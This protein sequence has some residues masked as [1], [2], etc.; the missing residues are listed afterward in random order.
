VSDAEVQEL[1]SQ[2]S[3][4]RGDVYGQLERQAQALEDLSGLFAELNR[5]TRSL[6]CAAHQ[7]R[8][9]RL[10]ARLE[11]HAA[12]EH[13]PRSRPPSAEQQPRSQTNQALQAVGQLAGQLVEVTDRMAIPQQPEAERLERL[14][15]LVDR[16]LER[17]SERQVAGVRRWADTLRAA[18]I[19]AI[20]AA[21]MAFGAVGATRC[22]LR[23]RAET[24]AQH[25]PLQR[26]AS[27]A[28]TRR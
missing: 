20:I 12:N 28:A 1:R 19:P 10:E 18:V 4:L 25:Q 22:E 21:V 24:T 16:M 26:A 13:A 8:L 23:P 14:T 17:Q 5:W 11:H 3:A 27:D 9:D 2:V 7:E 6:N 15:E